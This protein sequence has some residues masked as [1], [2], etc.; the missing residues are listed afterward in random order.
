MAT[1]TDQ[2]AADVNKQQIADNTALI[3]EELEKTAT[4]IAALAEFTI[5]EQFDF[6][7]IELSPLLMFGLKDH[8]QLYPKWYNQDP[9]A[10]SYGNFSPSGKLVNTDIPTEL[11]DELQEAPIDTDV[12]A[13]P[14][15]INLPEALELEQNY[16]VPISPVVEDVLVPDAP[17]LDTVLVPVLNNVD[18]PDFYEPN[19]P[20]YEAE[21]PVIPDD[22]A[23]P[24]NEFEFDGGATAFTSPEIEALETMLLDDLENGGYGIYHE[25]EEDIF[26]REIDRETSLALSAEHE[27]IDSY[28]S[29]GFL[30]PNGV[31]MQQMKKL[32]QDT[33]SKITGINRDTA[34][35]RADLVR[36][37]RLSTQENVISLSQVLSTYQGFA[38][39]RL[40]KAEQFAASYAIESFNAAVSVYNLNI[41]LY[42]SNVRSFIAQVNAEV[43][44]LEVNKVQLEAAQLAQ[45]LN[46][47]TIALYNAQL[48]GLQISVNIFNSQL[49]G[50]KIRAEIQ[51][52]KLQK[53]RIEFDIYQAEIQVDITRIALQKAQIDN[54]SARVEFY[55]AELAAYIAKLDSAKTQEGIYLARYDAEVRRK[56]I[57]LEIYSKKEELYQTQ[58]KQESDDVQMRLELYNGDNTQYD[59]RT[60]AY[61]A[62]INAT[63]DQ[64][65]YNSREKQTD[66]NWA[67]MNEEIRQRALVN[68]ITLE[69]EVLRTR[70]DSIAKITNALSASVNYSDINVS[71]G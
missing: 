19:I 12:P 42:D 18:I 3:I 34:I 10:I 8:A 58:L 37:T 1:L 9:S 56:G 4:D 68:E 52:D 46:E 38:Y 64:E 60:T 32:Q 35:Q 36:A 39:E 44:K 6:D 2:A 15:D 27:L 41:E 51:N 62:Y 61:K 53:Y 59:T 21:L 57:E 30:I 26:N 33:Q 45:S 16:T 11:T 69:T 17:P 31:L 25:N 14:T 67:K 29:R 43:A 47:S 63:I 48:S 71:E 40:L 22:F 54:E 65:G 66:L 20:L 55:R 50:T 24:A 70:V 28:A 49:A 5:D 7:P 13:F 23:S